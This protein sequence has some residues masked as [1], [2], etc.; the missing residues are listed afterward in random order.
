MK[1]PVGAAGAGLGIG[2]SRPPLAGLRRQPASLVATPHPQLHA[3]DL[4]DPSITWCRAARSVT[5][6]A[7]ARRPVSKATSERRPRQPIDQAIQRLVQGLGVAHGAA[8]I[9]HQR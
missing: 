7:P 1:P 4:G 3:V 9:D 5:G 8:A 2:E 6:Q